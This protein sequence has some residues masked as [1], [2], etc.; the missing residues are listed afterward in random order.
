MKEY[1]N[2]NRIRECFGVNIQ[3]ALLADKEKAFLSE[4]PTIRFLS[5]N[6][7]K[8]KATDFV[9]SHLSSIG[10]FMNVRGFDV[11]AIRML[12]GFIV[13]EYQY[14]KVTEFI[15]FVAKF[16]LGCYEKFYGSF[17]PSVITR[18]L[19]IF[20]NDK[21]E[22]IDLLERKVKPKER[23]S[24]PKGFTSLSFYRATQKAKKE[25]NKEF[26]NK[27]KEYFNE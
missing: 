10:A 21:R 4:V 11:K 13:S 25:N 3:S 27:Y 7:G 1:L 19:N 20:I 14:L 23:R 9:A 24:Y 8:D 22:E 26:F 12:A 18:S 15:Y 5:D 6:F 16:N 17:E 2:F